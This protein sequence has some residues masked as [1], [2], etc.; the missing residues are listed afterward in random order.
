MSWR[1]AF[2]APDEALVWDHFGAQGYEVKR[3]SSDEA[4]F[5]RLCARPCTTSTAVRS[6]AGWSS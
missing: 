2:P 5:R 1:A 4:L 6:C 3:G